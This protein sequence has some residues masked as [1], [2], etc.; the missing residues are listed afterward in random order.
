[1]VNADDQDTLSPL[2]SMKNDLETIINSFLNVSPESPLEFMDPTVLVENSYLLTKSGLY[3]G[4][5]DEKLNSAVSQEEIVR[6]EKTDK[7]LR[8]FI[9]SERKS[10]SR[11]KLNY[12]I[13]GATTGRFEE[14]IQNLSE[15]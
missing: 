3:E 8:R 4:I 14:A 12:L 6:I 5:M 11:L 10:R 13:C 15:W 9:N 2:A 7:F 1:M